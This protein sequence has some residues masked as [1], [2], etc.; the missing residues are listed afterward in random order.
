MYIIYLYHISCQKAI[1]QL[2][3]KAENR[4]SDLT[5]HSSPAKQIHAIKGAT[6]KV[7]LLE[8]YIIRILV[9]Y[10]LLYISGR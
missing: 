7:K 10:Y 9:R 5:T 3:F 8:F 2:I 1:N 6:V 4:G